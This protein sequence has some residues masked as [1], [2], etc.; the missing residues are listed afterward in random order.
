MPRAGLTPAS[1]AQAGAA[2]A[3]EVGLA[4]LSMGL[5]AERLGVRAPALYKHVANQADLFHRIA[6]LAANELAD[7]LR[8]AIQGRA[9]R[10]ALTAG[11]QA[12]RT[13]VKEHPGRY[14]AGN[15]AEFTGEDDPLIAATNRVVGSW[16]AMLHGYQIDPRQEV[17]A[18][19]MLRSLLHGFAL[20]EVGGGFRFDTE[21]DDSFVWMVDFLDRGLQSLSD[22]PPS[23][24]V[25]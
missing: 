15:A 14:A 21:V 22:H 12:M 10:E 5:L 24:S 20:L 17:H 3:D 13:Y 4:S 1:V 9:G 18:L 11:T 23:G 25:G 6:V 7:V 19:R 8:D 16:A 2:V